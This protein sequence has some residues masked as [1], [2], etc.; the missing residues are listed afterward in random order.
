MPRCAQCGRSMFGFL[1]TNGICGA[2][3]ELNKKEELRRLN[4][5]RKEQSQAGEKR[6]NENARAREEKI[7]QLTLGMERF[8][9]EQNAAAAEAPPAPAA[10]ENDPVMTEQDFEDIAPDLFPE[11]AEIILRETDDVKGFA[12][13]YLDG[14]LSKTLIGLLE[15]WTEHELIWKYCRFLELIWKKGDP[16]MRNALCVTAIEALGCCGGAVWQRFGYYLSGAFRDWINEEAVPGNV[17][18]SYRCRPPLLTSLDG[19]DLPRIVPHKA[20]DSRP[21]PGADPFMMGT[22]PVIHGRIERYINHHDRL[23]RDVGKLK[24]VDV[25]SECHRVVFRDDHGREDSFLIILSQFPEN[26]LRPNI[27]DAFLHTVLITHHFTGTRETDEA[28]FSRTVEEWEKY[29]AERR[30]ADAAAMIGEGRAY[31]SPYLSLLIKKDPETGLAELADPDH[32]ARTD[33]GAF[34]KLASLLLPLPADTDQFAADWNKETNTSCET[35]LGTRGDCFMT[36]LWRC[37]WG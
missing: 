10:A 32:Y 17:A 18:L 7:G 27:A 5:E 3:A 15:E 8:I 23:S 19:D 22:Y 28:C 11:K 31:G 24:W 4:E 21:E 1:L 6:R 9:A 30:R 16:Y 12:Y 35:I 26:Y 2:C 36:V 25:R 33:A 34:N 13:G 20:S 29:P 37:V 14:D